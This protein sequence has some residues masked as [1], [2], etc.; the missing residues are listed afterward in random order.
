MLSDN[1]FLPYTLFM[2]IDKT[3]LSILVTR[4]A[5]AIY[6]FYSLTL[7]DLSYLRVRAFTIFEAFS[8]P[9]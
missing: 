3:A 9:I 8:P 2:V 1:N 7:R 4:V 5:I 6:P